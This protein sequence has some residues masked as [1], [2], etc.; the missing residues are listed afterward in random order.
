MGYPVGYSGKTVDR[1]G[2]EAWSEWRMLDPEYQRRALA[3]MDAAA[4]DGRPLGIGSVFRTFARQEQLFLNRH[5]VVASGGCC[6]YQGKRWELNKGTAHA[7]PPGQSYH[8]AT[9]PDGKALAVDFIGDLRYL[10][11]HGQ[12]YGIIEFSKV[13][14]EPWHGQPADIPKGRSLYRPD[15]HHPLSRWPLPSPAPTTP[16]DDNMAVIYKL[17]DAYAILVSQ[18]D[19]RVPGDCAT[20]PGSGNDPKVVPFINAMERNGARVV[21]G[22]VAQV[23][24]GLTF[25]GTDTLAELRAADTKHAWTGDEFRAVIDRMAAG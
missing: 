20:W 24:P 12:T 22:T 16:E 4:A 2:L 3:I 9:T 17:T 8:E 7:A 1:A 13:N 6:S 25:I 10:A 21:T 11:E 18:L 14:R 15:R 5:R 23:C 19:T